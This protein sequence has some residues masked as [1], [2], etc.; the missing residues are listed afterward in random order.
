MCAQHNYCEKLRPR[1][2]RQQ[3]AVNRHSADS[4]RAAVLIVTI[5]SRYAGRTCA[6]GGEGTLASARFIVMTQLF[7]SLPAPPARRE[8]EGASERATL[9]SFDLPLPPPRRRHLRRGRR[10]YHYSF[11]SGR[12]LDVLDCTRFVSFPPFAINFWHGIASLPI[13]Q[14]AGR[15]GTWRE[16]EVACSHWGLAGILSRSSP[17]RQAATTKVESVECRCHCGGGFHCNV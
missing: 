10:Q 13:P 5:V 15:G 4:T 8:E 7:P 3:A 11:N 17:R 9:I 12:L 16:G 1:A 6:C 2:A 14:S